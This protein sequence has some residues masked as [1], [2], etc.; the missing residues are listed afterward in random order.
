MLGFTVFWVCQKKKTQIIR[1]VFPEFLLKQIKLSISF[2]IEDTMY[3]NWLV[4]TIKHFWIIYPELWVIYLAFGVVL[5]IKDF[6]DSK[7]KNINHS[8]IPFP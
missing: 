2:K 5:I 4:V 3:F 8:S 7:M 1:S 6:G